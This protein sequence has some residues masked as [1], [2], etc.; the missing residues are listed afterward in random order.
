MTN[1]QNKQ[2]NV[3]TYVQLYDDLLSATHYLSLTTG[4]SI[5]LTSSAKLVYAKMKARFRYF[6]S[7]GKGYYDTQDDIAEATGLSRKGVNSILQDFQANGIVVIELSGRNNVYTAIS[8]LEFCSKDQASQK[9]SK[10]L[11]PATLYPRQGLEEIAESKALL[12]RSNEPEEVIEKVVEEGKAIQ[13]DD[14]ELDWE[15]ESEVVFDEPAPILVPAP[16]K[17]PLKVHAGDYFSDY[18]AKLY[19]PNGSHHAGFL[20]WLNGKGGVIQDD[21]HFTLNGVE[22][23]IPYHPSWK[24]V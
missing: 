16:P 2:E 23:Y 9:A 10:S 18:P 17:D 20:K 21:Y 5:K 22:Y 7:V 14:W 3:P 12:E 24:A 1:F 11:S 19:N 13:E 4:K 6:K 15:E 8:S